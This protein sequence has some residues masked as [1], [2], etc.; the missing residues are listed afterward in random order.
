MFVGY[1]EP[2]YFPRLS[3]SHAAPVQSQH[4]VFHAS[5]LTLVLS[6]AAPSA[7]D[8]DLTGQVIWPAAEMLAAYL[9]LNSQLVKGRA[10]ACELG[11]GLGLV[12]ILAAQSCPVVL[13]DHNDIILD[14]LRRNA[15]M[16]TNQHGRPSASACLMPPSVTCTWNCATVS[17]ALAMMLRQ[18][19]GPEPQSKR[20]VLCRDSVHEAGV[21]LSK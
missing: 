12:G 9:A 8:Y 10:C 6:C 16:N 20:W 14:V 17:I 13:T 11:A 19:G 3:A 21:G 7:A 5:A 15:D 2:V 18:D 4:C 1:V